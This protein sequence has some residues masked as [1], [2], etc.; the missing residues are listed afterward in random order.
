MFR[1]LCVASLLTASAAYADDK[2]KQKPDKAKGRPDPEAIFKR[3]DANSDG[4][5]SKSE[6]GGFAEIV[7]NKAQDKGKAKNANGQIADAM[8]GR[9]DTN[10]DGNLSLDEFKKFNE[11][12]QQKKKDT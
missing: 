10:K 4:K 5:I 1:L 6:F 9:L 12:R 3:L 11:Q 2:P 7:R 8:F